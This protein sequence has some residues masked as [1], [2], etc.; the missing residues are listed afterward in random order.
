[1]FFFVL[2][3]R[4][5][6][7]L[8]HYFYGKIDNTPFSFAIVLPEPYGSYRFKGQVDLKSES[9]RENF[10]RFFEG[11]NWRIHPDWIYCESPHKL[12]GIVPRTPEDA[13]LQFLN[14]DLATNSFVWKTSMP[15]PRRYDNVTC[16]ASIL[17][18]LTKV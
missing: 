1:M 17:N 7:K 8:Q 11:N 9:K 3:K 2:Q 13:I 5:V 6:F 14:Y 4:P 10:T 16:E 18:R 12:S 15:I